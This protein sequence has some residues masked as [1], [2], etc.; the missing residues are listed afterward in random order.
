M[1][2][3]CCGLEAQLADK[4]SCSEFRNRGLDLSP[5]LEC[6]GVFLLKFYPYSYSKNIQAEAASKLKNSLLL[7]HIPGRNNRHKVGLGSVSLG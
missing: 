7:K 5:C 4:V 3:L 1:L 2:E 6:R